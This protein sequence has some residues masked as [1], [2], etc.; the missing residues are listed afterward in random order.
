MGRYL[1]E[2]IIY[3]KPQVD[4]IWDMLDELYRAALLDD[5]KLPDGMYS[6]GMVR[7]KAVK[8]VII[9]LFSEDFSHEGI[10]IMQKDIE[11]EIKNESK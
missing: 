6:I 5:K 1:T 11:E 4:E 8:N 7:Y 9:D 10:G 2:S 3:Y